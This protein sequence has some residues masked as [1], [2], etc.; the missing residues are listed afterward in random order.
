MLDR[1]VKF[2]GAEAKSLKRTINTEWIYPPHGDRDA[3]FAA[4]DPAIPVVA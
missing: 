1:Q 2:Q 3:I 4:A